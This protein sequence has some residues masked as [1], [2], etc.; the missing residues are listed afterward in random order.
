MILPS[1]GEELRTAERWN[2]LK[3]GRLA[4]IRNLVNFM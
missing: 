1:Y 2:H 4:Q 3:F